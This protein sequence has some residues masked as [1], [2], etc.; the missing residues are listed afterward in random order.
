MGPLLSSCWK[1][2]SMFCEVRGTAQAPKKAKKTPFP[3]TMR[4]LLSSCWIFFFSGA[5][6]CLVHLVIVVCFFWCLLMM[7]LY[8]SCQD[9][10]EK[11][12]FYYFTRVLDPPSA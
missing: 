5:C 10:D 12:V 7:C 9:H 8:I 1:F 6:R 3:G 4:P 2:C 11:N